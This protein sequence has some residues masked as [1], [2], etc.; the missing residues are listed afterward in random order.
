MLERSDMV[1]MRQVAV[2]V[3]KMKLPSMF[4]P[5]APKHQ[6][7]CVLLTEQPRGRVDTLFF[8][9]ST[10]SRPKRAMKHTICFHA[11][12]AS[13]EGGVRMNTVQVVPRMPSRGAPKQYDC[14]Y[15]ASVTAGTKAE[16]R[17][18]IKTTHVSR[19]SLSLS[20][21]LSLVL[22]TQSLW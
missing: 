5:R 15:C 13:H 14:C 6:V 21:S 17:E 18:H 4:I 10:H 3:R 16:I 2:K 9:F 22:E 20:L 19:F 7:V 1:A 8:R 11:A 12:S